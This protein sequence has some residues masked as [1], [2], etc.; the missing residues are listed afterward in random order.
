MQDQLQEKPFLVLKLLPP[1][2]EIQCDFSYSN[3]PTPPPSPAPPTSSR[4]SLFPPALPFARFELK[5]IEKKDRKMIEPS[6][7]S[8][9]GTHYE[10]AI[11]GMELRG[12]G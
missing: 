10:S 2:S 9:R 8:A 11:A 6:S 1:A 7:L 3:T 4:P 5:G 12:P